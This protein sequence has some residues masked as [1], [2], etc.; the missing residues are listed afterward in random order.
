MESKGAFNARNNAVNVP[1]VV[2]GLLSALFGGAVALHAR[3]FPTLSGGYPGPGL[4]PELMGILMVALGI[5]LA[6]H[7]FRG[8][9]DESVSGEE[10]N[11]DPAFL[12]R[13]LPNAVAATVVV[14][15]YMLLVE[16]LGFIAT[17]ILLNLGLMLKLGVRLLTA[18]LVSVAVSIVVY[19]LFAGVLYVPLPSGPWR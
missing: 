2:I 5:P 8:G 6:I 11:P 16:R 15:L 17:M 19:Y 7:G 18:I 3:G 1:N 10:D 9:A 13:A 4:F 12:R 14:L